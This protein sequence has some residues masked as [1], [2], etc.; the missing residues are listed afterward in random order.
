MEGNLQILRQT[1]ES[2]KQETESL[3]AMVNQ[4][5]SDAKT[6]KTLSLIATMY[7]PASLVVVS[8]VESVVS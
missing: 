3:A 2:I 5:S 1:S 8:E 4:N 6:L 7:L